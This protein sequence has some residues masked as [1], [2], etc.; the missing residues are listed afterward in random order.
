MAKQGSKRQVA[1]EIMTANADKPMIEV[2]QLIAEANSITVTAARSYYKYLVANNMAPGKVDGLKVKTSKEVS[3]TKLLK[4][5]GLK[6]TVRS[7]AQRQASMLTPEQ[8]E[9]HG[10]AQGEG[11]QFE[12]SCAHECEP[13]LWKGPVPGNG[14][15]VG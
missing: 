5:V 12:L 6:P 9:Q 2:L 13:L 3:A 15:S 14:S 4:E 11:E 8:K 7:K 1:I 10:G